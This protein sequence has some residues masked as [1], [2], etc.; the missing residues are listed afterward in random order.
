LHGCTIK[1]G[2]LVGIGAIVLNGAVVGR[3]ALIGA[4]AIVPESREIPEGVL[5]VGV[6][7]VVRQ[8]EPDEIAR[9]HRG[10]AGYV[11]RG[12]QYKETLVRI[13]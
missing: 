1:E 13:D 11:T 5:V 12:R 2:A 9:T 3:N 6:G 4:G 7:K 8:L 10:I